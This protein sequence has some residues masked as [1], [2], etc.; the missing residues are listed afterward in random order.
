MI[1]T[2]PILIILGIL[3]VAAGTVIP[4]LI[5]IPIY[6]F[7]AVCLVG[8]GIVSTK[9]RSNLSF[10][11]MKIRHTIKQWVIQSL[12]SDTTNSQTFREAAEQ[13]LKLLSKKTTCTTIE[14]EV[15]HANIDNHTSSSLDSELV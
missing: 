12:L 7:V 1:S 8:I 6:G 15:S 11:I 4:L 5:F 13:E 14:G 3:A 9:N 10:C 2:I